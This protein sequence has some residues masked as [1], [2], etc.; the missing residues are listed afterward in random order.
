MPGPPHP[1]S[2]P[3]PTTP[4]GGVDS[5]RR[6]AFDRGRRPVRA[7][8]VGLVAVAFLAGSC[9]SAEEYVAEADA[10]VYALV[11]ARRAALVEDP[12]AFSI[13]PPEDSLR[14]R[15]LRAAA[16]GAPLEVG[17]LT[18]ADCLEIAFENNRDAAAER[19]QLYRAA[20][21]LTLERWRFGWQ[22]SATASGNLDG[23]L[24]EASSWSADA[25]LGLTRLF[26]SGA[27]VVAGIGL[28][29]F[30]NL[31][32][33]DGVVLNSNFDLSVTQP[34]LRGFGS[35]IVM[36]SLTQAERD[37]VYAVRNYERF[38]RT[39]A[40]DVAS[41]YLRLLQQA[42]GL[43]NEI[44][45]AESVRLVSERNQALAR[46]GRLNDI[47]VDQARQNELSA[48]NGVIDAQQALDSAID[49][50][51]F[52][53]GLPIEAQVEFDLAQ[54]EELE[55]NELSD[56]EIAE[57]D[58]IAI[59]L[60][61]RYDHLNALGR[62]DDAQRAARIAEDQ[63]RGGL[64]LVASVGG[65]SNDDRP[66]DYDKDDISW[67][68]GLDLDLP[69]DQIPERNSYR[70]ALI[71]L[72]ANQRAAEEFADSITV[73]VRD[74]LRDLRSRS[75]SYTIQRQSV[76]LAERR[77]E[78]SSRNLEAGRA[79][80]RDLLE[81]QESLLSARNSRTRALIDFRLAE[82]ALWRDLELLE[83][84][85]GALAV[86][87]GALAAALEAVR[88]ERGSASASA[89]PR[90]ERVPAEPAGTS[91]AEEASE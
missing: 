21:D 23:S 64:G 70:N 67:G 37:L 25:D 2:V 20:L 72:Q 65:T 73:G 7:T 61:G 31:I 83:V 19:E 24:E 66:V 86:D 84:Q 77:V 43:A 35:E 90:T 88:L 28:G 47:Q 81:S 8:A 45:N 29:L 91:D 63:L 11:A 87:R 79:E 60:L 85:D 9:R 13:D 51:K 74:A 22:P 5:S 41:R 58:A 32:T 71:S 46:A 75:E 6:A 15:I 34:L 62:V 89:T 1:T 54:L 55:S 53:L 68:I 39:F 14:Q 38:R 10:D 69:V 4:S 76:A 56:V 12:E 52:F 78:S 80:T 3:H 50:F 42:D 27:R 40:F 36:E 57:D 16:A 26:G 44:A 59:A 49:D 48:S 33:E 82:L 18:L 30:E 17:S